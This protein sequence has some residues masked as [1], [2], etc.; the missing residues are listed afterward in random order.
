MR[1]SLIV[2]VFLFAF[3]SVAQHV[4]VSSAG[5][6][7]IDQDIETFAF[8]VESNDPAIMPNGIEVPVIVLQDLTQTNVAYG[9]YSDAGELIGGVLD[10]ASPR[11]PVAIEQRIESNRLFRATLRQEA[12]TVRTNVNAL[13]DSSTASI[14]NRVWTN[15][16]ANAQSAQI[17]DLYKSK[18]DLERE[19]KDL[20]G[21]VRQML[22]DAKD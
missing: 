8:Q 12:K 18:R 11:D 10:H 20:A 9:Y 7:S 1:S 5:V 6:E 17:E 13:V 3:V 16:S 2:C 21:V 4:R 19:V 15:T 22:K 14:T